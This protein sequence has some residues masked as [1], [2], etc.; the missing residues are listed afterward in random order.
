MSISTRASA[1]KS[2]TRGWDEWRPP[3]MASTG[4]L[5]CVDIGMVS[6]QLEEFIS[7]Y[8]I[9]AGLKMAVVKKSAAGAQGHASPVD[10]RRLAEFRYAIRKFLGFSEAAASEAGLTAQQHQALLTIKG[11]GEDNGLSVGDLASRLLVRH[12]SAAEL[13]K[14][15]EDAGLVHRNHDPEDGR[16]VLLTLT[17]ESE[18]R[19]RA[20]SQVHLDEISSMSPDLVTI[21]T[22]LASRRE[23]R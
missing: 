15:L 11:F 13:A 4:L 16:R 21:L 18:L 6:G 9:I 17:E 1:V 22:T 12:H 2:A 19:L 20:L 7:Y 14:R 10:Y 3:S 8:D 23:P 5:V